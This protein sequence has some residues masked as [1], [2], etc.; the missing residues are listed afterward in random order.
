[1]S[2]KTLKA[3]VLIVFTM[4]LLSCICTTP[5][6]ADANFEDSTTVTR[7]FDENDPKVD[8]YRKPVDPVGLYEKKD[9]FFNQSGVIK[10]PVGSNISS[11]KEIV[12]LMDTSGNLTGKD[13]NNN[14]PFDYGLFSGDTNETLNIQGNTVNIQGKTHS[15]GKINIDVQSLPS[16]AP[17]S[18]EHVSGESYTGSVNPNVFKQHK[19]I[20]MPDLSQQLK[21]PSKTGFKTEVIKETDYNSYKGNNGV[22]KGQSCYLN[23]NSDTST[24]STEGGRFEV[25][26]KTTY[27]FEGN[28]LISSDIKFKGMG[29]IVATGKITIQGSALDTSQGEAFIYSINSDIINDTNLTDFSGTMYAPYGKVSLKG[30]GMKISGSVIGKT[31]YIPPGNTDIKYSD[32]GIQDIIDDIIPPKTYF[33]TAQEAALT[34]VSSIS[35][36][37]KVGVLKYDVTANGNDYT[38]YDIKTKKNFIMSRINSF[39]LAHNGKSNLVDGLRRAYEMLQSST[40][41]AAKYIVVFTGD[42]PNTWVKE[43]GTDTS[44]FKGPGNVPPTATTVYDFLGSDSRKFITEMAVQGLDSGIIPFFVNY[45]PNNEEDSINKWEIAKKTFGYIV[46]KIKDDPKCPT[47]VK[48]MTLYY[49]AETKDELTSAVNQVV[50]SVSLT[51]LNVQINFNFNLPA[52]A[53]VYNIKY[54]NT[55]T[56]IWLD[57]DATNKNIS[58]S[59]FTVLEPLGDDGTDYLY[60]LKDEDLLKFSA[61]IKYVNVGKVIR[62]YNKLT[63]FIDSECTVQYKIFYA[64]NNVAK[65]KT[66]TKKYNPLKINVK[67]E[68]D[69]T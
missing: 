52:G 67:Y 20:D 23:Y 59:I 51:L 12:I 41:G 13:P 69:I 4:F 31:L 48:N 58:G 16:A 11:A 25:P 3:F 1:M 64:E 39:A 45:L 34:F 36:P 35:E 2:R 65:E 22:M 42:K 6:F 8:G 40:S 56:P 9:I 63:E 30:Y 24:F 60:R 28:L 43:K 32:T 10:L 62:S 68:I 7:S 14:T 49:S 5:V 66:F 19:V 46:Q 50:N 47:V 54:Y 44:Y 38:L 27:Y 33:N 15:N 55:S 61:T 17:E 57:T 21:D 18:Y 26:E 53:N 37:A 29:M